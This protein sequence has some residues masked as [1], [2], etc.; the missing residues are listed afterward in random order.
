MASSNDEPE[1][2]VPLQVTEEPVLRKATDVA[3]LFRVTPKT[4]NRWVQS[5]RLKAIHTPG[6]HQR[7]RQEDIDQLLAEQE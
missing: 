2:P 3:A 7:F 5:G 1:N 6:G 4:V